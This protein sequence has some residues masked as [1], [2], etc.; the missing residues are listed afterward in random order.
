M[1]VGGGAGEGWLGAGAS[2]FEFVGVFGLPPGPLRGAF[3][4]HRRAPGPLG[5]ALTRRIMLGC[6]CFLV[7]GEGGAGGA[8]LVDRGGP[9][10]VAFGEVLRCGHQ[11]GG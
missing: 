1:R 2:E 7:R 4:V 3:P 6:G 11:L 5:V 8:L 9:L 10:G